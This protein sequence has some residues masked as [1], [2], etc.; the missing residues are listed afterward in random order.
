MTPEHQFEPR[1][2]RAGGRSA[3]IAAI[4]AAAILAGAAGYGAGL[5]TGQAGAGGDGTWIDQAAAA[6]GVGSMEVIARQFRGMDVA[7]IEID[8][9]YAELYFAARDGN[10]DYAGHQVEHMERAM[11]MA[12]ER[13]PAREASARALFYP[14]IDQ[15]ET[16]I[17]AED[18]DAF[19]AGFDSLRRACNACHV[20]EDEAAFVVGVP[21]QRR[22]SI[23][24]SAS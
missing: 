21:T 2:Q 14:V 16:A 4:A 17:A 23:G 13:R 19:D 10:W 12:I 20:A 5:T 22:T 7:M 24:A 18:P 11:D 9:R 8:H 3:M 6:H 1:G 15:I